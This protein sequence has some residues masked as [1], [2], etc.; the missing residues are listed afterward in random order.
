MLPQ[1]LVRIAAVLL[2]LAQLLLMVVAAVLTGPLCLGPPASS[3]LTSSVSDHLVAAVCPFCSYSCL[4]RRA[5]PDGLV[6]A[7]M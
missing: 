2:L 1:V 3:L 5:L 4:Q 6:L 7:T